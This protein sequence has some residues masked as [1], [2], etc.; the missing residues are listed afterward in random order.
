MDPEL[1]SLGI[2]LTEAAVRNTASA[3]TDRITSAR[4]RKRNEETVAELEQVVSDLLDDK[5]ELQRIA[6]AFEQELVAQRIA[7]SD[8]EYITDNLLPKMQGIL[9]STS[10][11]DESDEKLHS[12]I[13][14][15][16]AVLSVETLTVLQLIGFNFRRAIGEP[17]TQV[18]AELIKSRATPSA[19]NELMLEIQR[20]RLEHEIAFLRMAQDADASARF[21]ELTR[22]QP[23]NSP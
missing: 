9:H 14:G 1:Q 4:A 23:P 8:I 6:Q 16:Q 5:A 10:G 21:K 13:E 20:L 2:Q 12:T 17:L 15:L 11:S 22:P 18:V 7:P 3:V 19:G